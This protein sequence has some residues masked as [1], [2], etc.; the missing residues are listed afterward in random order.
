MNRE[1]LII[2][3]YGRLEDSIRLAEE[4]HTGFEYN[5]FSLPGIY[6]DKAECEKRIQSYLNC[7]H[8]RSKDT[9]HGAFMDLA[10]ASYDSHIREYSS[11]LIEQSV[12]IASRLGVRGAVFHTGLVAGVE[13]ERYLQNWID[14]MEELWRRICAKYPNVDIYLENTS[15]RMPDVLVKLAERLRDVPRFGLCLDY[16]HAILTTT[17]IETWVGKMAPHI[18]HVHAND[19]DL[20]RDLHRVPGTGQIDYMQMQ[21]LFDRYNVTVPILLELAGIDEQRMALN[22]MNGL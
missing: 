19:N 1:W 3:E 21:E 6:E 4:Y 12:E 16:A 15:E 13:G 11:A 9:L 22:Y 2:P 10:P 14:R 8:D 18:K 7:A 5:D 17:D 20:K